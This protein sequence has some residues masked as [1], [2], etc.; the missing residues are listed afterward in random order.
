MA[1]KPFWPNGASGLTPSAGE[2]E[3]PLCGCGTSQNLGLTTIVPGAGHS[4]AWC[5]GASRSRPPWTTSSGLVM[6]GA[7]SS[8]VTAAARRRASSGLA[9][10]DRCSKVARVCG[11]DHRKPALQQVLGRCLQLFLDRIQPGHHDHDWWRGDAVR[12]AHKRSSPVRYLH[13]LGWRRQCLGAP[14]EAT[15]IGRFPRLYL[16]R[17]TPVAREMLAI[18]TGSYSGGLRASTPRSQ[19]SDV[20]TC[21]SAAASASGRSWAA[22][23]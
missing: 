3:Q 10:P 7:A 5:G 20:L 4:S 6:R 14:A 11:G 21:M 18:A 23:A 2:S 13:P 15:L 22:S 17:R 9:A 8:R 1:Y 19:R 16:R 12:D